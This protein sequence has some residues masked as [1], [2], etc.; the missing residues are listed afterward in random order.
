MPKQPTWED[1]G[2]T[3][4]VAGA[5][6]VGSYDVDAYARGAQKIADAGERFGASVAR[7]EESEA[8]FAARRARQEFTAAQTQAITG[9]IGLRSQYAADPEGSGPAKGAPPAKPKAK[10]IAPTGPASSARRG[11]KGQDIEKFSGAKAEQPTR[12][13][14]VTPEE[15]LFD[16][17]LTHA[18]YMKRV[19]SREYKTTFY[20]AYPWLRRKVWIHHAIPKKNRLFRGVISIAELHALNNLRGIPLDKNNTT[21]LSIIN[22]KWN[23]FIREHEQA[24]TRPTM[25]EIIYYVSRIVFDHRSEFTPPY[26]ELKSAGFLS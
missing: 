11:P 24:G 1:L 23:A 5:R 9:L 21:H 18:E 12:S 19:E 8:E 7:L 13:N 26:K 6:P 4:G 14:K 2:G 16:Q 22:R 15:H 25:E 10:P 3:P 20:N 17:H